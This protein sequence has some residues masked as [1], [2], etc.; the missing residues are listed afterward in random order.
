[1][2]LQTYFDDGLESQPK[3]MLKQSLPKCI[4]NGICLCNKKNQ[5]CKKLVMH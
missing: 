3:G 1:L 4:Q 5:A 2:F